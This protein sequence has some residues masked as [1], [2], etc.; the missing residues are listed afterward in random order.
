MITNLVFALS[1]QLLGFTMIAVGLALA[2]V[3]A[4]FWNSA[5]PETEALA[6]LEIMG[7]RQ[8]VSASDDLKKQL[9][10]SVRA[11]PAI[12]QLPSSDNN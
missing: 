6:P 9:L 12:E 2:V 7:E 10:N 4:W 8:F 5:R 11:K 1:L 3:T